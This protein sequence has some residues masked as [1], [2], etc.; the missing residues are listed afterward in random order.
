MANKTV[1][2]ECA[3]NCRMP[4]IQTGSVLDC[5]LKLQ[6]SGVG[7][8]FCNNTINLLSDAC[9]LSMRSALSITCSTNGSL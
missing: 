9:V 6:S 7:K 3:F 5:L 1:C 2:A 8:D 4:Q